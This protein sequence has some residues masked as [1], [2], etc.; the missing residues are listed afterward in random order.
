MK[1]STHQD[2]NMKN[3][4]V[5]R[6]SLQGIKYSPYRITHTAQQKIC[7]SFR[8]QV[9]YQWP[10]GKNCHPAHQNIADGRKPVVPSRV[11]QLQHNT[12]CRQP[13]GYPKQNPPDSPIQGYKAV[14]CVSTRYQKINGRMVKDIELLAQG[15]SAGIVVKRRCQVQHHH[16]TPENTKTNNVPNRPINAS[17]NYQ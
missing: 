6:Q 11:K 16:A 1:N 5:I 9:L 12:G 17:K 14:R 2:P 13:P 4:V 15:L 8:L 3:R 7:Q 10:G